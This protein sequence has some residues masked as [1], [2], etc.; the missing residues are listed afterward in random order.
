MTMFNRQIAP[1]YRLLTPTQKA[2]VD[3]L[4]LRLEP[5]AIKSKTDLLTVLQETLQLS[6]ASFT[7]REQEM[8]SERLVLSALYTRAEE[9]D[10]RMRLAE[11]TIMKADQVIIAAHL[12]W[13][14]DIDE[15]GRPTFKAD[16]ITPDMMLALESIEFDE[17]PDGTFKLKIKLHPKHPSLERQ[18]KIMKMQGQDSTYWE[19]QKAR[20]ITAQP[21]KA[22]G[23][24]QEQQGNAYA[25]LL[26]QFKSL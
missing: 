11:A 1:A 22:V 8:L 20:R 7:E 26:D 12:G 6:F 23:A 21:S 15:N 2:L 19:N 25:R 24:D 18:S 3:G 14:V 10:D 17:K 4:I 16:E 5:I 13:F 9:I